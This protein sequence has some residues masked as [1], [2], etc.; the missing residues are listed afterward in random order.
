LQHQVKLPL[1]KFSALANLENKSSLRK[2]VI[3]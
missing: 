1:G 3:N 2:I